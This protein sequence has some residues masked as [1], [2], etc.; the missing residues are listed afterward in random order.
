MFAGSH[1]G[2]VL[3][4]GW[5]QILRDA[6]QRIDAILARSNCSFHWVCLDEEE[7]FARC[8][9]A[10]G[11]HSRYVVDVANLSRRATR[12][13]TSDGSKE[14][15][16]AIDAIILD[17]ERVSGETCIVCGARCGQ[18]TEHFGRVLPLCT[19]HLPEVVN[20]AGEEGLEGVWRRAILVEIDRNH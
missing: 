5:Q 16:P 3:Y 1:V 12:V 19:Q 11:E 9:Y 20:E 18:R 2:L 6:F 13:V 4:R 8:L 17:T 7:G 15:V 10:L 14:L